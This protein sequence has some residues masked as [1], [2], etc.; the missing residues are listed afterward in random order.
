M[1]GKKKKDVLEFA[2]NPRT[3][4]AL[5]DKNDATGRFNNLFIFIEIESK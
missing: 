5:C 1:K 2:V 3:I 4:R